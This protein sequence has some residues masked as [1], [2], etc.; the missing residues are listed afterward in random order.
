MGIGLYYAKK[1]L[2]SIAPNDIINILN[3]KSTNSF[4]IEDGIGTIIEFTN[5]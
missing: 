4:K 3:C 5:F 2:K 1:L